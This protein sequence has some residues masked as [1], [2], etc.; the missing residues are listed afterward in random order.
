MWLTQFYGKC[1]DLLSTIKGVRTCSVL[2]HD[3]CEDCLVLTTYLWGLRTA[4]YLPHIYEGW[5]LPYTYHISMMGEDF[6][7]LTT[8]IW[9][10]RTALYLP[11]T[12][13]RMIPYPRHLLITTFKHSTA[14][15]KTGISTN[16]VLWSI[17]YLSRFFSS[18][19]LSGK[20]G[21]KENK[22]VNFPYLVW[23]LLKLQQNGTNIRAV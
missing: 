23:M 11:M 17:S 10:V 16:V 4:L 19:L 20:V 8:Y 2:T 22:N 9:G 21:W 7:V 3:R 13:P 15:I 14:I 12:D 18:L 6:L 5:G 1:R